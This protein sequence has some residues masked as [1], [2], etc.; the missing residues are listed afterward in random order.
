MASAAD[1]K[2]LPSDFL[3]Q[4]SGSDPNSFIT[5]GPHIY[6][7]YIYLHISNLM[8]VDEVLSYNSYGRYSHV[9]VHKHGY[10]Y[11]LVVCE[12]SNPAGVLRKVSLE[13]T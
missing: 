5:C 4:I 12:V 13:I 6:C 11:H 3:L 2:I 9:Y 7:D 10:S 1:L 8:V